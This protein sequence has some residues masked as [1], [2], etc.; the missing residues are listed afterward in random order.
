MFGKLKLPG[1]APVSAAVVYVF[2]RRHHLPGPA[3]SLTRLRQ[4]IAEI[5][6]TPPSLKSI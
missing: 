2:V 5:Q 1:S 3:S 6:R 4:I